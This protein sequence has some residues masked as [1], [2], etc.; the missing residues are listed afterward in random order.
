MHFAPPFAEIGSS[1]DYFMFDN[2]MFS[3]IYVLLGW[4]FIYRRI[5]KTRDSNF[6][7][8]FW[9]SQLVGLGISGVGLLLLGLLSSFAE[10]QQI[11]A[12]ES[13]QIALGKIIPAAIP[14]SCL[15]GLV[16]TLRLRLQKVSSLETTEN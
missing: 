11:T 15:V 5:R 3:F 14:I 16:W 4:V 8:I 13:L 9:G 1:S 6:T 12:N 10:P 2:F 7:R